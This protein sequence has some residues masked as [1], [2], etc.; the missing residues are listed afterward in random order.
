MG[1]VAT[2]KLN[3]FQLLADVSNR[4][5]NTSLNRNKVKKK[6]VEIVAA[7]CSITGGCH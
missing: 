4:S 3:R 2:K 5:L 7:G 6:S 1:T